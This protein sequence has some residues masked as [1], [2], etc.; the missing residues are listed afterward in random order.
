MLS[1]KR[2]A[3]ITGRSRGWVL[4]LCR[5]GML[6]AVEKTYG[7][8][9]KNVVIPEKEIKKVLSTNPKLEMFTPL[10]YLPDNED[11]FSIQQAA[12]ELGINNLTLRGYCKNK[13]IPTIEKD[14]QQGFS[15][16][17]IKKTTME[18]LKQIIRGE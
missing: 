12:E 15:G 6:P 13:D 5:A 1:T 7:A 2:V 18:E 14:Y 9:G 11:S 16:M 17:R 10:K 8:H 3:E 4:Q